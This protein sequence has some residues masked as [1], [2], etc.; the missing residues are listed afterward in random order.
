MTKVKICG[1]TTLADARY[2]SGAGADYLG[3]IQHPES[4]RYVAPETARDIINWVYG[5]QPVGVFVDLDA[6]RVNELCDLAGFEF[7]QLHGSESPAYCEWIDRPII[8]AIR[9]EP[10]V[11]AEALQQEMDA[12]AHIAEY[13]LLDT[14]SSQGFGGTGQAFDWAILG[15]V[16]SPLPIFLAG[17]LN[18]QNV[19]EAVQQAHPHAV[20]V[21]SG[22]EEAPGAKDFAKI[23]A[24]ISAVRSHS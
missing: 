14:A 5:A 4:S 10:N 19:R 22:V 6:N 3:F 8:K 2:A 13:L 11:T 21:A 23:D 17:G 16:K 1:I 24:F 9:V 20:D 7:A 18:P 15:R 12:Y